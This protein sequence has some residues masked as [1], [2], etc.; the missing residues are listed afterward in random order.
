MACHV[1]FSI[2]N[3][4]YSSSH[5]SGVHLNSTLTSDRI[6]Q[7]VDDESK[8]RYIKLKVDIPNFAFFNF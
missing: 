3:K 8:N 7:F 5:L 2:K 1:A 6:L 4:K